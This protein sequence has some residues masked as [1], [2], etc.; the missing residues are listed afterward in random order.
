MP[1]SFEP[2]AA[3]R[4]AVVQLLRHSFGVRRSLACR[5]ALRACLVAPAWARPPPLKIG[6]H[7]EE[8]IRIAM[9][10]IHN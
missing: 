1:G 2:L 3:D 6:L 4:P 10:P 5:V 7:A 8:L 9:I